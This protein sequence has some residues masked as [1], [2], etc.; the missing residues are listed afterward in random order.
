[1]LEDELLKLRFLCGSSTALARIYQKYADQLL[2]LAA[3][4]VSDA[5]A[6]EDVLHDVFLKFAQS[7]GT[8]RL[9]GNLRSYLA[10]CVANRARDLRRQRRSFKAMTDST[11]MDHAVVAEPFEAVVSAEDARAAARAL[12][13]LPYEQ[14]EAVLLHVTAGMSFREIAK[15]QNVSLRTAQGRYRYA[16][17]KL[18]SMLVQGDEP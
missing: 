17:D 9:T 16:M 6:A 13:E 12:V 14:R 4:L 1:M 5:S 18:R 2:I 3:G 15:I 11:W 7:N 8:F 10:T